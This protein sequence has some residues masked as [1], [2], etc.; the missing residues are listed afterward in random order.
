LLGAGGIKGARMKTF[1]KTFGKGEDKT[2]EV[3]ESLLDFLGRQFVDG[4][5]L[6]KNFKGLKA[7]ADGF[8]NSMGSKFTYMA[9]KITKI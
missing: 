5:G 2:E 8:A 9:T 7:E 6:P 1:T 4:Y 3:T